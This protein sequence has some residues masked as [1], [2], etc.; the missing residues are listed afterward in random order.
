MDF[1]S[2]LC[3]GL[4][5]ATSYGCVYK[6][7]YK[8]SESIN[9]N[10]FTS[11]RSTKAFD[12]VQGERD[13]VCVVHPIRAPRPIVASR[14][15]DHLNPTSDLPLPTTPPN[16]ARQGNPLQKETPDLPQPNRLKNDKRLKTSAW[17]DSSTWQPELD[18]L[19]CCTT[20][21]RAAQRRIITPTAAGVDGPR[22][23][24]PLETFRIRAE[25]CFI[26]KDLFE[27]EKQLKTKVR[28]S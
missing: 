24:K 20:E 11:I 25:S 4:S 7:R 10:P 26:K 23:G 5:K 14:R 13:G 12:S 16:S 21:R 17:R 19:V 27:P 2:T 8:I 3:A 18:S 9:L 22:P 1:P 6:F 28:F 15:K